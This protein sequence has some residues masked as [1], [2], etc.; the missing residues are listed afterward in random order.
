MPQT[1]LSAAEFRSLAGKPARN[2]FR[3]QWTIYDG[4]RFQ[5][6]AEADYCAQLDIRKRAGL[7]ADYRRQVPIALVVHRKPI[8]KIIVDFEVRHNDGSLEYV[9]VKGFATPAFRLKWKLFDALSP[10]L[11]KTIVK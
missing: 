10:Q 1:R 2:K 9:D 6:K 5:S 7:I 4:V 8:C 3:N 11:R